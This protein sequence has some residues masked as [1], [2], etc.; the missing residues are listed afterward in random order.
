[1]C[2]RHI[3]ANPV[4]LQLPMPCIMHRLNL[5]AKIFTYI[6]LFFLKIFT[7]YPFL[8]CMILRIIL[9][10]L[11]INNTIR[12]AEIS[13]ESASQLAK[14]TRSPSSSYNIL[15]SKLCWHIRLRPSY[16]KKLKWHR[17]LPYAFIIPQ[18]QDFSYIILHNR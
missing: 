3:F 1:M 11:S 15:F 12:E 6:M 16:T 8:F 13:S 7:H 9:I 5:H 18:L 10:I 2:T 14:A 4:Q 17:K